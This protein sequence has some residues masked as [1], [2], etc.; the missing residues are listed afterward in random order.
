MN[1]RI[2]LPALF[3]SAVLLAPPAASAQTI[4]TEENTGV[5]VSVQGDR[6]ALSNGTTVRLEP[7]VAIDPGVNLRPGTR[8][9]VR[10]T[11]DENGMLAADSVSF[12]PFESR[13]SYDPNAR[14]FP[15]GWYDGNG[16]FHR[17]R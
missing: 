6:F 17:Y 3:A 5:I 12:H 8:V 15:N 4:T 1:V 16:F 2:L 10:G 7:G 11:V 13:N 14:Y 9:W